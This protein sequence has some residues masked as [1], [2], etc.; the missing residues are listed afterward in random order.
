[1][2]SVVTRKVTCDR[3]GK[4]IPEEDRQWDIDV[5]SLYDKPDGKDVV[6]ESFSADLC[7]ECKDDVLNILKTECGITF[8]HKVE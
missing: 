3:C 4:N 7:V 1:M 8:E 5:N 2:T 6:W